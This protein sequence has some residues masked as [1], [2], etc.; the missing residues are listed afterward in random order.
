MA[1]PCFAWT[2]RQVEVR[3]RGLV[4]RMPRM[5][6]IQ[7]LAPSLLAAVDVLA[8]IGRLEYAGGGVPLAGLE[9]VPVDD[10]PRELAVGL[11]GRAVGVLLLLQEQDALAPY[12]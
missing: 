5:A 9:Q 8:R 2:A 11:A 3:C 6:C 10:A 7:R 12:I 4:P 1:E